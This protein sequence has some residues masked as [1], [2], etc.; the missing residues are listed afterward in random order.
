[1]DANEFMKTN[2]QDRR[3][4]KHEA[5]SGKSR[6]TGSV[7]EHWKCKCGADCEGFASWCTACGAWPPKQNVRVDRARSEGGK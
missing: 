6:T 7:S 2:E 4:P 3:G 5:L 1:M